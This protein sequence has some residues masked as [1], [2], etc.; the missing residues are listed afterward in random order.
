MTFFQKFVEILFF[1]ITC[2]QKITNSFGFENT[3][4]SE[5][6]AEPEVGL[7]VHATPTM[8]QTVNIEPDVSIQR[9]TQERKQTAS[10]V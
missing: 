9:S 2:C 7:E 4:T 10:M 5:W 8:Q 6:I 3:P 1:P